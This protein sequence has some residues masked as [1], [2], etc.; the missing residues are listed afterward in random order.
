MQSDIIR[1]SLHTLAAFAATS[2]GLFELVEGS[3]AMSM[4]DGLAALL[5][6]ALAHRALER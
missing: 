2:A 4:A 3:R 5:N 6:C 1:A